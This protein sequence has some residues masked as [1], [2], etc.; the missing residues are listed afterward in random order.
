MGAPPH[1]P[2]WSDNVYVSRLIGAAQ[3]H[4]DLTRMGIP[5]VKAVAISQAA[6]FEMFI[7][8]IKQRYHG[9]AKQAGLAIAQ[10]RM[11]AHGGAGRYI[12]VV[13]EDVDPNDMDDV[14]WAMST[15]ADPEKDIEIIHRAPTDRLDPLVGTRTD[16]LL[17]TRAIIDATRPFEWIKEFPKPVTMGDDLVARVRQKWG[18]LLGF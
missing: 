9:H 5:D 2:K 6:H 11:T 18:S 16:V 8:S 12:I 15:R 4:N 3:L 10:H 1:R 7:V 13:D 17:N 14:I